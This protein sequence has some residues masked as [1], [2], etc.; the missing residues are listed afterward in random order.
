MSILIFA[1]MNLEVNLLS[2]IVY[3]KNEKSNSTVILENNVMQAMENYIWNGLIKMCCRLG[4]NWYL[5]NHEV[6][7]THA[8]S[9]VHVSLNIKDGPKYTV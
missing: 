8:N 7:N 6:I 5:Q 2:I 1:G 3:C 9:S 4:L